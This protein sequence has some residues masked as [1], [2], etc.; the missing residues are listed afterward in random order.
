MA[1]TAHARSRMASIFGLVTQLLA[2]I[3]VFVINHQFFGIPGLDVLGWYLICGIP[4]W[5][6]ALLVFRQH[7]LA[8]LEALDLEELRREKKATGGGDALFDAEGGGGIGFMV[9]RA[10]LEWMQ[11]WL[12]PIFGLIISLAFM[13][14]GAWKFL[15]LRRLELNADVTRLAWPIVHPQTAPI[16][17]IALTVLTLLL[18]LVSRY[19]S[20]LARNV[21]WQ[22]LRGPGSHTLGMTLASFA[23]VVIYAIHLYMP[24]VNWE[25]YVTYAIPILMV[26]LG[27]ETFANFILDIYRPRAP[28]VVPRACFDSRLLGLF[29][30]PGGFAASLAEAMN[31]QFGFQVSQTWFYQLLQRTLIPLIG[32]AAVIVWLLTCVVIVETNEHAIIERFGRQVNADNPYGP[33]VYLKAPWPIDIQRTFNTGEL[34]QF[35]VGYK[36]GAS[37][38]LSNPGKVELWTDEK[39]RGR[40]H[41]NFVVPPP[42]ATGG[43]TS[44]PVASEGVRSAPVNLIRMEIFVQYQIDAKRLAE[45]TQFNF[46]DERSSPE[47]MLQ[48]M[49]WAEVIRIV[50]HTPV[51]R[52]LDTPRE[53]L[54]DELFKRLTA[55]AAAAKLG[56][57]IAYVGVTNTHPE[58]TVAEAYRKVITARQEMVTEI[59]KARVEQEKVLSEVAGDR[60]R[61][62]L[63]AFALGQ[64]ERAEI[65]QSNLL[66]T[67][68]PEKSKLPEGLRD[69][70]AA[71][72]PEFDAYFSAMWNRAQVV[73]DYDLARDEYERGM[74][75]S[76]GEISKLEQAKQDAEKAE[77]QAASAV[78]AKL[79]PLLAAARQTLSEAAAKAW[80]GS[81]RT[82][83]AR[84]YWNARIAV[85]ASSLQGSAGVKLAE[86][87]VRRWD[88]EMQAAG[89]L[90]RVE[91]ERYA[92][93]ASPNVYKTRRYLEVLVNGLIDS[94]K[95]FFAFDPA[96]RS[97]HLRIQAEEKVRT[98]MANFN[99]KERTPG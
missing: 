49:A 94:R 42:A 48:S 34:Q 45:Y 67:L 35:A 99:T 77:Q 58:K 20:G 90:A 50:A 1:E 71:L 53:A 37:P 63:L 28:G 22:L 13:G 39:H 65:D 79:A 98:D 85:A 11:K 96:G 30:E 64:V 19:A 9:A 54:S 55:D 10:R 16:L 93:E 82:E 89:K 46:D 5:F 24:E 43:P 92:Y 76:S 83:M 56:L 81:Q 61:A 27:F 68:E 21:E 29:S 74:G 33:G 31:Y 23:L 97:V 62:V 73:D 14:V 47:Q 72:K 87:Q 17:L 86:A 38:D 15:V 84:G 91:N 52:L 66:R 8:A 80:I 59:R 69:Q 44:Q 78:D 60:R 57:T 3:A 40:E 2:V 88:V 26:A 51:E 75:R 25:R 7:E 32:V 6:I 12:V 36:A 41:F 18:F 95:Y 4:I 70:A